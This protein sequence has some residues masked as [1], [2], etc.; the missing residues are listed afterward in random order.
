MEGDISFFLPPI[1]LIP[2]N[3]FHPYTLCQEDRS[4]LEA[5]VNN[6]AKKTLPGDFLA[7]FTRSI[8]DLC[9]FPAEVIEQVLTANSRAVQD[10]A[11]TLIRDCD[12]R[13]VVAVFKIGA[14][15]YWL[16][17]DNT[18]SNAY[19]GCTS[20]IIPEDPNP[21]PDFIYHYG[22][23][24]NAD[25]DALALRKVNSRTSES[26]EVAATFA[27]AA[28][29]E[30]FLREEVNS[31]DLRQFREANAVSVQQRLL[32][33]VLK[34]KFLFPVNEVHMGLDEELPSNDRPVS[35]S[36]VVVV[37][38]RSPERTVKKKPLTMLRTDGFPR[39][40]VM[41]GMHPPNQYPDDLALTL[42][43]LVAYLTSKE[44]KKVRGILTPDGLRNYVCENMR[45]V[46]EPMF[47]KTM[48]SFATDTE[49]WLSHPP[50]K[51]AIRVQHDP[52]HTYR[53]VLTEYGVLEIESRCKFFD[54]KFQQGRKSRTALAMKR[55]GPTHLLTAPVPKG[56]KKGGD[57]DDEEEP[58]SMIKSATKTHI[59]IIESALIERLRPLTVT[60]ICH[61]VDLVACGWSSEKKFGNLSAKDQHK[62]STAIRQAANRGLV[63]SKKVEKKF[64]VKEV[65]IKRPD[66]A[67]SKNLRQLIIP[68]KQI[69]KRY[70]GL[71][72]IDKRTP[73]GFYSKQI[74]EN[75]TALV[76][77]TIFGNEVPSIASLFIPL[78]NQN[79]VFREEGSSIT[80]IYELHPGTLLELPPS[81]VRWS[82]LRACSGTAIVSYELLGKVY[83]FLNE[84][85]AAGRRITVH[86][87]S[88][89]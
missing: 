84:H 21:V 87:D 85:I 57:G 88:F 54:W 77:W 71:L 28:L 1:K 29:M 56:R 41:Q 13:F 67:P 76:P 78:E 55:A 20:T 27:L 34:D 47:N 31:E 70:F 4:I 19:Y 49:T 22:F 33:S 43:L 7:L 65:V 51:Q 52:N 45:W 44:Q 16:V 59:P 53:V 72:H 39:V 6:G 40:V 5:A 89:G 9:T 2:A 66:E 42:V 17:I 83:G 37:R 14:A 48:A 81:S 15:Q 60:E 25:I 35:M 8:P 82:L 69:T 11:L 36:R 38:D 63:D 58:P 10:R 64:Y 68:K 12:K 23:V 30:F 32:L 86:H 24:R 75:H 62:V 80:A 26:P 46:T 73:P 3:F 18:E 61:C 74:E 79:K 50:G